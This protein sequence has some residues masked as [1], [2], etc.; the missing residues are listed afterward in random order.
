MSNCIPSTTS[1]V[2]SSDF[3]SSTVIT[4][5]S[6]TFA[7]ACA[8]NSPI[9]LSLAEIAPTCAISEL[10]SIFLALLTNSSITFLEAFSIPF[11]MNT[12]FAPEATI[13]SPSFINA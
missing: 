5:D 10:D 3:A 4:P 12:G 7:I 9:S 13:L 6:P 8:I 11:L 2:V 1:S